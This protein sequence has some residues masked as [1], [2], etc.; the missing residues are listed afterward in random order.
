MTMPPTHVTVAGLRVPV[1]LVPRV[2]ASFRGMYPSLTEGL[3]D[4][5]AVRAVL[6]EWVTSNLMVWEG[7]QATGTANE[8]AENLQLEAIEKSTEAQEAARLAADLIVDGGTSVQAPAP[9]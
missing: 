4:D 6:K 2:I 5:A 8:T 1:T 3:D 9:A 7:L